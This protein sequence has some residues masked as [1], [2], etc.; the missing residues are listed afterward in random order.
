[1]VQ[2]LWLPY[3]HKIKQVRQGC[4]SLELSPNQIAVENQSEDFLYSAQIPS[5]SESCGLPWAIVSTAFRAAEFLIQS[6]FQDDRLALMQLAST[7]VLSILHLLVSWQT[8]EGFTQVF[9]LQTLCN[10]H[11]S[12]SLQRYHH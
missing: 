6:N 11:L 5:N 8:Q 12:C 1:M 9:P 3:F 10:S 4:L 2:F 7:P